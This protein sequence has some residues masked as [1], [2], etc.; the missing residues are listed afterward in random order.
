MSCVLG[1]P[2]VTSQIVQHYAQQYV[3]EYL[4]PDTRTASA[5]DML[6]NSSYELTQA[7]ATVTVCSSK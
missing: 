5:Q 6:C 1:E 7:V 2:V 4:M 3:Q